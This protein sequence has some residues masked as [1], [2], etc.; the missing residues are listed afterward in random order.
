[1]SRCRMTRRTTRLKCPRGLCWREKPTPTGGW[2]APCGRSACWTPSVTEGQKEDGR[3]YVLLRRTG[4]LLAGSGPSSVRP[5]PSQGPLT[6]EPYAGKPPVRFGGRGGR[7]N[8][9][10]L[11]L[12]RRL[13]LHPDSWTPCLQV[14]SVHDHP[15][16]WTRA[17][18]LGSWLEGIASMVMRLFRVPVPLDVYNGGGNGNDARWDAP[19]R[20]DNDLGGCPTSR[21]CLLSPLFWAFRAVPRRMCGSDF[22]SVPSRTRLVHFRPAERVPARL[23]RRDSGTGRLR[24]PRIMRTGTA[25]S[26]C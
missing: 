20:H 11:P 12:S 10:S 14:P 24:P 5:C 9:P 6:G 22:P 19:S 16:G 2:N 23:S 8:R 17:L 4:A 7:D 1:M 18:E 15:S 3:A 21:W 13:F 25:R 26:R